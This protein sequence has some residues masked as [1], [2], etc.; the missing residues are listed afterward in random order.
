MSVEIKRT[1]SSGM[2]DRGAPLGAGFEDAGDFTDAYLALQAEKG[3]APQEILDSLLEGRQPPAT[4]SADSTRAAQAAEDRDRGRTTMAP[5]GQVLSFYAGVDEK[6]RRWD[7]DWTNIPYPPFESGNPAE[8]VNYLCQ[9]V[10]DLTDQDNP[11]LSASQKAELL[12]A[13][14]HYDGKN[15]RFSV[16]LEEYLRDGEV[17]L[18]DLQA[19]GGTDYHADGALESAE[20]N[21]MIK[22]IAEKIT[23]LEKQ[24]NLPNADMRDANALM[25][26]LGLYDPLRGQEGHERRPTV[27][28][29]EDPMRMANDALAV[30]IGLGRPV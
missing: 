23:Q 25:S 17:S 26:T 8:V 21:G 4:L 30:L 29:G 27:W 7:G 12:A 16:F 6:G 28:S 22:V 20:V 11:T 13:V 18:A 5:G 3:G 14:Y 10:L 15:K 9:R 24:A 1:V 19:L 2:N